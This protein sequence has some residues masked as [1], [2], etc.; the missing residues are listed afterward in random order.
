MLWRCRLISRSCK[1][2]FF[3]SYR[4]G[5]RN[6]QQQRCEPESAS[7][8]LAGLKACASTEELDFG[9]KMH[10][11][12]IQSGMIADIYIAS[13]LVDMYAKSGSMADARSV[14]EHISSPN[15]VSWTALM[16]GYAENGQAEE[17]LDL[18]HRME[19]TGCL[20]N[21]RAFV[22]AIKAC[23]LLSAKEDGKL[24]DGK[25]VKVECLEKGLEIFSRAAKAGYDRDTFVENCAIDM[26][27]KCGSLRMARQV[28]DKMVT[29]SVVSWN[30]LMLGYAEN[31]GGDLALELLDSMRAEGICEPNRVT[32]LAAL[33]A[34]ASLAAK[35]DGRLVEG[36][37]VKMNALEKGMAVHSEALKIGC[38]L[39]TFVGNSLVDMYASCGSILDARRAFDRTR[40]QTVVSWNSLL[41]G[42]VENGKA[43]LGLR[44]FELMQQ[45]ALCSP[46]RVTFLVALKACAWLA[47][48]EDATQLDGKAAKQGVL[49][50]GSAIHSQAA[51]YDYETDNFI[52]SSLI[53]MYT[54]C[55]GLAQAQS[56]FDKLPV[57]C[58]VTWNALILGYVESGE[59]GSSL[60]LFM[61]MR[62]DGCTPDS[63]TFIAVLKAC[64]GVAALEAGKFVCGEIYKAGVEKE[65]AVSTGIVDLFGKCGNVDEAEESFVSTDV[66]STIAWTALL[67]GYSR[68]G[69]T[70][71]AFQ[72]FQAMQEENVLP[73]GITFLCLLTAC[74]HAGLV[75]RGR[76]YFEAMRSRY[77]IEPGIE[78]YHCMI[79]TLA[80]T[81]KLSEALDM[82]K[83]MPYRKTPVAWMTL[84]GACKKWKNLEVGKLAFESLMELDDRDV[85]GYML[86]GSIYGSLGMWEEQS[87]I[88]TMRT[89][90][91]VLRRQGQSWWTDP[92]GVVHRF[93]AGD[94]S[95]YP[96]GEEIKAL[97]KKTMARIKKEAGYVAHLASVSH[98]NICDEA[99][100]DALCGHSE[101]L[102]L[103]C[104]LLNTRPGGTVRII[105]NLR[106]CDD[107]HL[108]FCA[109]SAM[110]ARRILCRDSSRFHVFGDGKCSCANFW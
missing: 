14:F 103:A 48:N 52:A 15:V 62:E 46:N 58:L 66:R 18:F 95:H 72:L 56:V 49:E 101:K 63:V 102:A 78:H 10:D 16:L 97:L 44:L 73:D 65:H 88:E 100:E 94:T 33:K 87:K 23:S 105:K 75:E 96:Q 38:E 83:A 90:A 51:S 68:Q 64:A 61:R 22:A 41:M 93:S 91:R 107:C 59:A 77:S 28:F 55:G 106:V 9:R 2:S 26:F 3:R 69:N 6:I 89:S 60:E 45:E 86:M 34:C 35:E 81:N 8:L 17:S 11:H 36:E 98:H 12:A 40:W 27:A 74:S 50:K 108:V 104:A 13:T 20:P 21:S 7:A 4:I 43:G 39:D 47:A 54:N 85:A 24:V 82:V 57:R 67:A 80:R 76:R 84:L 79:D 92:R 99:K 25:V 42:Y 53:D 110:E 5:T 71:Y 1:S 70:R 109:V 19:F 30:A 37:A 32:I 29:R 31:G